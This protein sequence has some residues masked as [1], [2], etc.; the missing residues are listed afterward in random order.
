MTEES[1]FTRLGEVELEA[2]PYTSTRVMAR[3]DELQRQNKRLVWWRSLA[4]GSSMALIVFTVTTLI[5]PQFF[6]SKHLASGVIDQAF[7]LHVDTDPAIAE[8]TEYALVELP[9]GLAF[10]SDKFPEVA[11]RK[12]L[13]IPRA[14]MENAESIPLTLKGSRKGD[15]RVFVTYYDSE[16]QSRCPLRRE[17]RL[18]RGS[19]KESDAPQFS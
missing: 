13:M 1:L 16:H 5:V 4:L 9:E 7:S 3:Y 6:N 10:Y 12:S 8:R 15:Q 19:R 2:S 14:V 11:S 17:L 18:P